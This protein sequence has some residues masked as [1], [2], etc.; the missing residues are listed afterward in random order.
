M[1]H[2]EYNH[3]ACGLMLARHLRKFEDVIAKALEKGMKI[4][5]GI[6]SF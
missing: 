3:F 1:E 2:I 4:G 5:F 6:V